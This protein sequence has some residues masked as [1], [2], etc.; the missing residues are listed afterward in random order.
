MKIGEIFSSVN[1]KIHFKVKYWEM[2]VPWGAK[3]YVWWMNMKETGMRSLLDSEFQKGMIKN[4]K[5]N[6]TKYI[7]VW[8][9]VPSRIRNGNGKGDFPK[10]IT[11]HLEHW[12][13]KLKASIHHTWEFLQLCLDLICMWIG[14]TKYPTYAK[15][16]NQT[17]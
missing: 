15:R 14:W 8:F 4:S 13:W 10:Q 11:H 7:L 16:A 5:T 1:R 17:Y 9:P 2:D 12:A 3:D 6:F